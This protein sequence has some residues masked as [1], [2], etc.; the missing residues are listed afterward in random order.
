MKLSDSQVA[1]YVIAAGF[2]GNAAIMATAIALRESGGD[3]AARGDVALQTSTWGASIG[4]FQIRSLN[5]QKGTGGQR[6][7]LANL[8]PATNARHAWE[9]SNHG[10]NWRPWS[11]YTSGAYLTTMGR[12]RTAVASP[13]AGSGGAGPPGTAAATTDPAAAAVGSITDPGT[14]RRLGA[15]ALGGVLIVFALYRATDAQQYIT[16]AV[17]VA[18]KVA[19]A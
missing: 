7:E 15:F 12:A 4:L 16:K 3:S 9:I 1:G 18:A 14:W 13:T 10:T 19:V 6:D 11:V 17:K 5:A 2:S 8:D